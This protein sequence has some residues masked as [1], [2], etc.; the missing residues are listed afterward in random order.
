LINRCLNYLVN[1]N[2]A[3]FDLVIEAQQHLFS[4]DALDG[5]TEAVDI[6]QS[7][8]FFKIMYI[9]LFLPFIS[10]KTP[11]ISLKDLQTMS[12]LAGPATK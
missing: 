10:A 2:C 5:P 7:E 11:R 4:S 1:K 3:S 12:G 6:V 8:Q 9:S